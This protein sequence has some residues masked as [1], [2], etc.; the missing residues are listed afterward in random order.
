MQQQRSTE[1]SYIY[2][3][4]YPLSWVVIGRASAERPL[5]GWVEVDASG[6]RY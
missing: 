6:L 4:T 5:F 3:S 1:V 2:T